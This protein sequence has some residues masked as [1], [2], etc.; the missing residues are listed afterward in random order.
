[1]GIHW[2]TSFKKKE[3]YGLIFILRE[4]IWLLNGGGKGRTTEL[5]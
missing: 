2:R 3:L 4:L 1:M 5:N